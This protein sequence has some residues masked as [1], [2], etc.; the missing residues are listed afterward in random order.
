MIDKDNLDNLITGLEGLKAN[1]EIIHSMMADPNIVMN[2]S[3]E[4][5]EFMADARNS[6]NFKGL[7]PQ[8]MQDKINEIIKKHNIK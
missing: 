4:Q 3:K 7:T 1:L 5:L 6:M 2:M 8:Q